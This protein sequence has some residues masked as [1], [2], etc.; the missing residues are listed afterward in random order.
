MNKY[1]FSVWIFFLLLFSVAYPQSAVN[2]NLNVWWKSFGDYTLDSL[3][4]VAVDQ[5]PSILSAL[6]RIEM[7]RANLQIQ[8]GDYYP[9]LGAQFGWVRQESSGNASSF[10]QTTSQYFNPG[11]SLSWEV[12]LFGSIRQRVKA[13]KELFAASEE[14]YRNV[15]ISLCAEVAS[16]YITMRMLQTELSVVRKNAQSQAAVLK[17]T[18]VRYNTGLVSKLDVAQAKSVYYATKASIPQIEAEIV[19]Y[20]NALAVLLGVYPQQMRGLTSQEGELPDYMEPVSLTMTEE[21]LIGR[22]D[23]QAS[24]RQVEAQAV[25]VGASKADWWPSLSFRASAGASARNFKDIGE[26]KSFTY[27]IAPTLS[28]NLFQ[29]TKLIQ[30]TR[31]AKA[32]LN[33]A[34]NTYNQ[35]L[36]N[37]AQ[38]VDN[39]VASYTYSLKQI[40]AL[41][42]V[43]N[44]GE[45]TL[46]LSV[47]LYKQGLAPFQNVLDAQ[48]SLLSYENQLVQAQGSSLLYLIQLYKATTN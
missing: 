14:E 6:D 25:L 23:V 5:N 18:E 39:A 34:I 35:T 28:I 40:V 10:P 29:G 7:A 11:L 2:S 31:L 36:L 9:T 16:A 30:A 48:R 12:D 3:V 33:Q 15:M 13:Q 24:I 4:Q 19:Q 21:I 43:K 44:Q 26:R 27:E 42:E 47:D 8:R 37:A 17:I 32:Q 22:P 1:K 45:E 41:R 46:R 38:E 20:G